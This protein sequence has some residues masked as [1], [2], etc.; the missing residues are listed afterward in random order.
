MR[1]P[2][3]CMIDC[4]IGTTRLL[5]EAGLGVADDRDHS[6]HHRPGK[7]TA[8]VDSRAPCGIVLRTYLLVC[9]NMRLQCRSDPPPGISSAALV[10]T[11][12]RDGR[13]AHS[14][15]RRYDLWPRSRPAMA[16]SCRHLHRLLPGCAWHLVLG[17]TQYRQIA[18][19]HPMARCFRRSCRT[20]QRGLVRGDRPACPQTAWLN[21]RPFVEVP[22]CIG[23]MQECIAFQLIWISLERTADC[24]ICCKREQLN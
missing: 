12:H 14:R 9:W 1:V 15:G 11:L 7:S 3:E 22:N 2:A 19:F 17:R 23:T 24:E 4:G 20:L 10:W 21:S 5:L 8:R 18:A 16:D 6:H 13:N